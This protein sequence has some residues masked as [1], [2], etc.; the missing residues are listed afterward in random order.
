MEYH[1]KLNDTAIIMRLIWDIK[2]F[3]FCKVKKKKKDYER[4]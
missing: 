2:L 1:A 3:I 4:I